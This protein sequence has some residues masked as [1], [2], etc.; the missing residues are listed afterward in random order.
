MARSEP[1]S[2]Y[3]I[4]WLFV[5]FDLPMNDRAA[6]REYVRFRKR[7]LELGFTQLQYSVYARPFPSEEALAPYRQEIREA[8][9][10][11]GEVRLLPVTDRQFGKMENYV[12]KL[13][14]ETEKPPRQLMLF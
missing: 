8:L 2:G 14:T 6:R 11:D 5:F 10:P 13:R 12:G 3:K 9:P 7:L 4:M 1:I